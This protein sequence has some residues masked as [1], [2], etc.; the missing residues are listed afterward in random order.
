[1]NKHRRKRI[2]DVISQLEILKSEIEEIYSEEEEAYD[3]L[4][5]SLQE[6]ERGEWMLEAVDSLESAFRDL[7]EIIDALGRASE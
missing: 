4:P 2:E 1:M 7:E 5:A 6:S 3:N